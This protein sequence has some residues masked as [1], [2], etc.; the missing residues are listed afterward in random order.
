MKK[1]FIFLLFFHL[2]VRPVLAQ[3]AKLDSLEALL[4]QTEGGLDRAQLLKTLVEAYLNLDESK[5]VTYLDE[6]TALSASLQVDSLTA[7][8]HY[9][10][11][12]AQFQRGDYDAAA[13]EFRI[14]ADTYHEAGLYEDALQ[15]EARAGIMY[16]LQGEYAQAE[17]IFRSALQE[18]KQQ[19]TKDA[20]AYLE[21]QM[22][23][24]YHYQG[25]YD[26]AEWYYQTSIDTYSGLQDSL[27]MMRPMYNLAVLQS[28][29]GIARKSIVLYETIYQYQIAKQ[30]NHDAMV[31]LDGLASA[32][33][34]A[35]ML[36]KAATYLK[37]MLEL[38]EKVGDVQSRV[39]ALLG[40][41]DVEL[42]REHFERSRSYLM[43]AL[44]LS[45][46]LET[47]DQI[48][49]V[50]LRL[51]LFYQ[52]QSK[53]DSSM[54]FLKKGLALQDSIKAYRH[55]IALLLALGNVHVETGNVDKAKAIAEQLQLK[56]EK[57]KETGETFSY[58][59]L[60]ATIAQKEGRHADFIQYI[61]PPFEHFINEKRYGEA[62]KQ[63][64]ELLA[65]H[66]A[67]NHYPE[68]L[69]Y[70]E[71]A[72]WLR[73]SIANN[74]DMEG[75]AEQAKDFEFQLERQQ[76]EAE[77]AKREA[78]LQEKST[79]NLIIAIGAVALAA[80]GFGFFWNTRRQNQ[81]ITFQNQQLT[82]INE[83][84]D[85]LF[86]IIGHDLRKPAIAFQG[87]T[88]KVNYLLRKKD[89]ETLEALG[90][91]I[92]HDASN[93]NLLTENL[94]KWALTQRDVMPYQPTSLKLKPLVED[95]LTPL[96]RSL[97]NKSQ[98]LSIHIPEHTVVYSDAN[99]LS[100]IIRNL[101]DN[102][103]KFTPEGGQIKLRTVE[104]DGKISLD[105]EDTG[106]GIPEDQLNKLFL[107]QNNNSQTGTAG[108]KGS[109]L[110]LHLA[111]ELSK[112]NQSILEVESQL[113]QGTTFSLGLK[114][115]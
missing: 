57:I 43:Q 60:L 76:I 38:S 26:S 2:A 36:S 94:L 25:V 91:A 63:A 73:D 32:C 65:A 100:T 107:L 4:E 97:E 113:G 90:N 85:R 50:L 75:L 77:Q 19:R 78:V 87:I 93:L 39:L 49:Y 33:Q 72:L 51:G 17:A 67:L 23:T 89:F 69:A 106:Q 48:L 56:E 15:S 34:K 7:Y 110:G 12:V 114:T 88:K 84:K 83:T 111:Y 64:P 30:A 45:E 8:V 96:T 41:A 92:E 42:Q 5:M 70:A 31:T 6:L 112:L 105:I 20:Q 24:L 13:A 28:E 86:A 79:Q 37:K 9:R 18:A 101:V 62:L 55:E 71:A 16:S 54:L 82:A 103:I 99:A 66:K 80:L 46:A 109:G 68:A 81:T 10:Q 22:A 21:N 74:N 61:T 53:P 95:T 35:G 40:M 102:A 115:G 108:E 58:Y 14:A 104:E 11:A 98:E 1:L 44:T 47:K 3:E 52:S 27:S 59:N 29:L